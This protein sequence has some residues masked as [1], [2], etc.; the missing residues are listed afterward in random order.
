MWL[1]IPL[2]IQNK[3]IDPNDLTH[4]KHTQKSSPENPLKDLKYLEKALNHSERPAILIGSGVRAS[5]AIEEVEELVKKI[6][7]PLV[8]ANSAPDTYSYENPFSRFSW[9]NGKHSCR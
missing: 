8:Y 1:D 9:Y 4:F 3:R 7:I 6:N 5:G 2:D